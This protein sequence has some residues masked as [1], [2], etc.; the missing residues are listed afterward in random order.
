[1]EYTIDATNKILG[2]LAS[3]I[4]MILRGKNSPA[5]DPTKLTPVTV[6]VTNV[7]K[8]RVTGNKMQQKLYR[9]HSGYHGGLKEETLEHVMQKDPNRALKSAV[10]GMLPKNRLRDRMM[11]N[12]VF[13][14]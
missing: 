2:R 5:Y 8:M 10:N 11:K 13:E 6:R 14:K 12:L 7:G 1:M 4:A 3:D 9:H